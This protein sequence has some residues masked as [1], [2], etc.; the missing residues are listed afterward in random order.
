MKGESTF[1][2][3]NPLTVARGIGEFF[4]VRKNFDR[5]SPMTW[6]FFLAI[7]FVVIGL[8]I[9]YLTLVWVGLFIIAVYIIYFIIWTINP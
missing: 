2:F 8:I 3:L 9:P 6:F 4:N 1:E 5:I 7:L